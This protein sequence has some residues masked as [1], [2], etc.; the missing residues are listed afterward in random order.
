MSPHE[1][2]SRIEASA[3]LRGGSPWTWR[4]WMTTAPLRTWSG[5]GWQRGFQG[6]DFCQDIRSTGPGVLALQTRSDHRSTQNRFHTGP[7]HEILV[8][9]GSKPIL[10]VLGRSLTLFL[11]C[12]TVWVRTAAVAPL[13]RNRNY[14]GDI[15][16]P[17]FL[18]TRSAHDP[19]PPGG[20]IIG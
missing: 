1:S 4:L 20:D 7:E 11:L 17:A 18:R 13:G 2:R 8:W 19:R 9:F 3:Q 15:H 6:I 16:Y 10:E 12:R 14:N 5:S